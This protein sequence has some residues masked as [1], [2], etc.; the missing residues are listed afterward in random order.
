MT[1]TTTLTYGNRAATITTAENGTFTVC[2]EDAYTVHN[3][4]TFGAAATYAAKALGSMKPAT[5]NV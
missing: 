5:S 3:F 1:T 2:L 4:A